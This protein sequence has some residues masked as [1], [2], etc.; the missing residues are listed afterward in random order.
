MGKLIDQ[1]K[2]GMAMKE[3]RKIIPVKPYIIIADNPMDTQTGKTKWV[4]VNSKG[5]L[6]IHFQDGIYTG[7][8]ITPTLSEMERLK[9]EKEK[10]F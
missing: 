4:Y 2:P 1:V 10:E 9:A 8:R 6:S 5:S 3:V 7:H